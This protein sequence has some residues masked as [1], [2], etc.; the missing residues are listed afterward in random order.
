[1][2]ILTRPPIKAFDLLIISLQLYTTGESCFFFR[3]EGSRN[4]LEIIIFEDQ[5]FLTQDEFLENRNIAEETI[6]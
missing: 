1:V 4:I 5:T 3:A 6:V 2:A